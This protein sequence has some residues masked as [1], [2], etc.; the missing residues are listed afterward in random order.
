MI[1]NDLTLVAT[2]Q[3][4]VVVIL[5]RSKKSFFFSPTMTSAQQAFQANAAAVTRNYF[6]EP[7]VGT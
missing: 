1:S 5:C 3:I 6:V 2:A 7:R 4:D